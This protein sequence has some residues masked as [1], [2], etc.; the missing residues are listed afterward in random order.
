MAKN[1]AHARHHAPRR[2]PRPVA[3]LRSTGRKP[4]PT[5]RNP[6]GRSKSPKAVRPAPAPAMP[7]PDSPEADSRWRTPIPACPAAAK[8]PSRGNLRSQQKPLAPPRGRHKP[9]PAIPT[10]RTAPQATN[11]QTETHQPRQQIECQQASRTR[12]EPSSNQRSHHQPP[13]AQPESTN[14]PG[15]GLHACTKGASF[16]HHLCSSIEPQC[17]LVSNDYCVCREERI[18]VGRLD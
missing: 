7:A 12:Q 10:T 9:R 18:A 8:S 16:E 14:E 5:G 15:S 4:H 13:K 3:T 1:L 11:H 17:V 6:N 2:L